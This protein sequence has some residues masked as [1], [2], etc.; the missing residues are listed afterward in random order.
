MNEGEGARIY[1]GDRKDFNQVYLQT[2]VLIWGPCLLYYLLN[3]L[4]FSKFSSVRLLFFFEED[5]P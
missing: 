2:A 5:Q 1:N 3:S 4:V